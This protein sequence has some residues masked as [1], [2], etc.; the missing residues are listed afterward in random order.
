M[1]ERLA[2]DESQRSWETLK[3]WLQGNEDEEGERF[4]G[5]LRS[6]LSVGAIETEN[7]IWSWHDGTEYSSGLAYGAVSDHVKTENKDINAKVWCE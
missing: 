3:C 5:Q 6:S 4:L 1:E 7:A 2:K